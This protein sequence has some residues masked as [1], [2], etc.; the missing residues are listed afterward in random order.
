MN[1]KILAGV[2]ALV[3]VLAAGHA[4]AAEKVDNVFITGADVG[5]FGYMGWLGE[6]FDAGPGFSLFFGYGITENFSVQLD[7]IPMLMTSPSGDDVED[8]LDTATF[9]GVGHESGQFGGFGI[10]GKLYPR[11]RFRDADFLRVQP[12]YTMGLGWLPF[13]YDY[14]DTA[15][16]DPFLIST[17]VIEDDYEGFNMLYANLGFG[18][19]FMLA[20]WISLGLNA[21]IYRFFVMAE[22]L[23]GYE[24]HEDAVADVQGSM[25]Y[26]AGLNLTFQW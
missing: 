5:Y 19:D 6:N 15:K 1:R 16:S 14:T 25:M 24:L 18:V 13:V 12:F 7:Y 9:G 22:S 2:V 8:Y 11:K 4:L 21:R 23:N 26:Q 17:A 3:F 10:S 20:R